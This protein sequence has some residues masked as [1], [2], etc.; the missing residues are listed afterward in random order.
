MPEPADAR[1]GGAS[2]PAPTAVHL[3]AV[4]AGAAPAAVMAAV[5]AAALAAGG[6]AWLRPGD[7]VFIK[8]AANSPAPYPATTAPLALEAM[9]RLLKDHGA[10]RVAAGDKPGVVHVHQDRRRH[11]GRGL[12]VM[13]A[14]GLAEAARRGGAELHAFDQA[15]FDA[16]FAEDPPAGGHWRG[17]LMLPDILREVD[18]VVLLPRVGRHVLAGSSL[19]LKL[20]VGWLRDDSRLEL[21]RDAASFLEKIAEI[22]FVPS[23]AGRVRLTLSLADLVL[24][25]FG[26]D[27]GH[28][29]RPDPGLVIA[30]S[31]LLAHDMAA[32]AWLDWCRAHATPAGRRGRSQDPY[33]LWPGLFNRLFVGR[34]WGLAALRGAQSYRGAEL[35]SPAA[36][37]VQARAAG[38][39]GGW[40]RV[41]LKSAGAAPPAAVREHIARFCAPPVGG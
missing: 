11:R 1:G 28:V 6:L 30:S 7:S 16:Y 32:L 14:N 38:L 21:H 37:R 10:G 25:T 41:D 19:G 33:R 35:V 29:A 24:T 5:A 12:E 8:L 40:P 13:A 39:R 9:A 18:H 4:P 17:H 26:P 2:P 27:Q 15:G 36:D 22:S 20:A 31:D 34:I 23:L 3:A